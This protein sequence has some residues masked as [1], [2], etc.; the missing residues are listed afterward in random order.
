MTSIEHFTNTLHH[1]IREHAK[2]LNKRGR[3]YE[4]ITSTLEGYYKNYPS[5]YI[6]NVMIELE[7]ESTMVVIADIL[8]SPLYFEQICLKQL[9]KCDCDCHNDTN[10]MHIMPCCD[11]TYVQH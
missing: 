11:Q 2:M 3:S 4:D 6:L 8:N 1:Y 7:G 9:F 5:D 10:V